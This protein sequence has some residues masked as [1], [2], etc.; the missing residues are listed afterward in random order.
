M[1]ST[2]APN[3]ALHESL[4]PMTKQLFLL[5]ESIKLIGWWC[6]VGGS[7]LGLTLGLYLPL[8]LLSDYTSWTLQLL[9]HTIAY[10]KIPISYIKIY[11]STLEQMTLNSESVVG[12]FFCRSPVFLL[13]FSSPSLTL[14]S[15]LSS[16]TLIALYWCNRNKT[17][18]S[19]TVWILIH[20]LYYQLY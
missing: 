19:N 3:R 9:I 16:F 18:A 4:L 8:N 20:I 13:L 1:H 2:I 12:F 6:L 17:Y 10:I 7:A 5:P 14:P 15:A 11:A